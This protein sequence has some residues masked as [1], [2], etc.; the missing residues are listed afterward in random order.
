MIRPSELEFNSQL[1][2]C[3]RL[4]FISSLLF[5]TVLLFRDYLHLNAMSSD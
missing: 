1:S 2:L 5:L 3:L 4:I